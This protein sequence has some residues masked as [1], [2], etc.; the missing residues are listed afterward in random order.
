MYFEAFKLSSQKEVQ[1]P[2][3]CQSRSYK[4]PRYIGTD[5]YNGRCTKQSMKGR[6]KT[7]FTKDQF[8]LE[9]GSLLCERDKLLQ[10]GGRL[11]CSD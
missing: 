5:R 1:I 8:Y 3:N 11:Q 2:K 7:F 9:V 10:V 6:K 4:T